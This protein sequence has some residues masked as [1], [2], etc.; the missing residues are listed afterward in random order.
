MSRVSITGGS[1]FIGS[2]VVDALLDEGHQVRVIDS[3][4]PHRPDADWMP[5]DI[6]D[7][8]RLA[9]AVRGSDA[10]FHLAA[11]A[12]VNDIFAAPVESVALNTLGTVKVLEAAR[13]ADAGRVILA[14]TVWVYAATTGQVVDESTCFQPETDRHLYVSTK[15]AAEM[16][17][18]DY[19]NLYKR[20]YTVL[21]YGIP[22]GPRMRDNLVIA[23]FI[24]RALQGEAL[25]IDGDGR[26]ERSFVYVE[27]L[28]R[29]HVLALSEKAENRTYNLDG[30]RAVS[31]REIAETVK[32]LVG[33]VTVEYGPSR[34]G[35]FAAR[36]VLIDR[37]R[38]ELGWEPRV[39]FNEGM[40]RTLAWYQERMRL[41]EPATAGDD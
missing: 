36:K 5:V 23:A 27:D 13:Q 9:Q 18:R 37:A 41:Q 21:R 40:Q 35:D 12:D 38:E 3:R 30:A 15:V 34:P 7:G 33:D 32:E 26:Q 28:A 2:H 6:M 24:R 1:G 16:M 29:A 39:E 20:P 8:E 11:M 10:V 19:A 22:Y 31:I 17:C 14:S 25:K 4:A